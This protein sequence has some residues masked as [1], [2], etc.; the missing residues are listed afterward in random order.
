MKRGL[1]VREAARIKFGEQGAVEL[2]GEVV[3]A[4]IGGIDATLDAGKDRIR[5]AGGAGFIFYVP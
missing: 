3:A 5:S 2:F 1:G 4:L